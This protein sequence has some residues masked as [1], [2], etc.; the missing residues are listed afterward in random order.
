M[1]EKDKDLAT[2]LTL[3][4]DAFLVILVLK[5]SISTMK[6]KLYTYALVL[7]HAIFIYGLYLDNLYIID[8]SHVIMCLCIL[9]APILDSFYLKLL[10]LLLLLVIQFLWL[11]KGYCILM[12][13]TIEGCGDF[14]TFI[15]VLWTLLLT[16]IL[17]TNH[18]R[19]V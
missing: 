19:S 8:A 12:T 10:H 5:N 7:V 18:G 2:L 11:Y 17:Y 3:S 16:F 13:D 6:D 14:F 1:K 15:A 4:I 9:I